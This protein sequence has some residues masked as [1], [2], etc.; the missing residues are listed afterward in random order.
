M[1]WKFW[2]KYGSVSQLFAVTIII[3]SFDGNCY[4]LLL[5][6]NPQIGR[7]VHYGN[8][9]CEVS[10]SWIQNLVEFWLK[11]NKLFCICSLLF[12]CNLELETTKPIFPHRTYKSVFNVKEFAV[13]CNSRLS[14]GKSWNVFFF[15]IACLI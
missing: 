7:T 3:S 8:S 5:N 14:V 15:I 4:W 1:D 12:F 13:H 9:S 6:F 2:R 11:K 10:S